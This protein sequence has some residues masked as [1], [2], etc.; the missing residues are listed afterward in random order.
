MTPVQMK[1]ESL[2]NFI[3][4]KMKRGGDTEEERKSTI[5]KL[6]KMSYKAL[7]EWAIAHDFID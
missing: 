2:L 5:N 3:D 6:K 1:K 4:Y 7:N